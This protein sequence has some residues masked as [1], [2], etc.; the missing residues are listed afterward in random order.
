MIFNIFYT[1]IT[2]FFN[3]TEVKIEYFNTFIINPLNII[4]VTIY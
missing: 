3:A 2:I 4:N 1:Y